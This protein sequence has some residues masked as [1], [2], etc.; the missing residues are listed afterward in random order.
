MLRPLWRFLWLFT[1][2]YRYCL[3]NIILLNV[4]SKKVVETLQFC[5][6]YFTRFALC[7]WSFISASYTNSGDKYASS[8][9][10]LKASS[11]TYQKK[12]QK[13][14]IVLFC[15]ENW[16]SIS[17]YYR[18]QKNRDSNVTTVCFR[19]LKTLLSLCIF[20]TFS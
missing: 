12:V 2:N 10:V 6:V 13:L 5:F 9:T 20:S 19:T 15:V 4:F 3:I 18:Q 17:R 1:S 7:F 8:K 14:R 11:N 16:E